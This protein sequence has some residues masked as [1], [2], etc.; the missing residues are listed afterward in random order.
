MLKSFLK[1]YGEVII[2]SEKLSKHWKI[3]FACYV[4][5]F[6]LLAWGYS[7]FIRIYLS[8]NKCTMVCINNYNE[9]NLE[10]IVILTAIVVCIYGMVNLVRIRK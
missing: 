1:N 6:G 3:G 9:A 5:M 10:L 7:A 4:F 2:I 8:D